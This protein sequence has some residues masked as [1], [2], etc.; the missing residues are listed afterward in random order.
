MKRRRSGVHSCI[1]ESGPRVPRCRSRQ[2]IAC[3]VCVGA[4]VQMLCSE[5]TAPAQALLRN[6]VCWYRARIT[7]ALSCRW[8]WRSAYTCSQCWMRQVVPCDASCRRGG[9]TVR[10]ALEHSDETATDTALHVSLARRAQIQLSDAKEKLEQ[11]RSRLV[12]QTAK[13]S[14]VHH[15]HIGPGTRR[16]GV[17]CSTHVLR[18]ITHCVSRQQMVQSRG[19]RRTLA[20]PRTTKCAGNAQHDGGFMMPAQ[21]ALDYIAFC[22]SCSPTLS[23]AAG[24]ATTVTAST[25]F[26]SATTTAI[27]ATIGAA[28]CGECRWCPWSA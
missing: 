7:M 23:F 16:H 1:V 12:N 22:A 9:C 25:A 2:P 8:I 28:P 10:S 11:Y 26:A 24:I 18:S 13:E 15:N 17:R 27:A 21:S 6:A 14:K 19:Q 4:C 20:E 5:G 3:S